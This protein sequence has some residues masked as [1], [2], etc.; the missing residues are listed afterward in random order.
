MTRGALEKLV[1]DLHQGARVVLSTWDE[2]C[3]SR[4]R[5]EETF[6]GEL[7][8]AFAPAVVAMLALV[9]LGLACSRV[10]PLRSWLSWVLPPLRYFRHSSLL[11]F[12]VCLALLVI[13]FAYHLALGTGDHVM[14]VTDDFWYYAL[15]AQNAVTHGRL[16]F[17]GIT[18]RTISAS[19]RA[20]LSSDVASTCGDN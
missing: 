13:P 5:I 15:V 3:T 1:H 18:P 19:S 16:S 12:Y 11:R 17:D 10:V 7:L 8:F 9:F 14:L 2:L 4:K 6:S 20:S